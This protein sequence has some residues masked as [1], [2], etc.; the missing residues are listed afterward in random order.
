MG[1]VTLYRPRGKK[2]WYAKWLMPDGRYKKRSLKIEDRKLAEQVK[3]QIEES[4]LKQEFGIKQSESMRYQAA[5]TA[6]EKLLPKIT[7]AQ[8]IQKVVWTRFFEFCGH[9]TIN[10]VIRADATMFMK[11]LVSENYAPA[12]VNLYLLY[13]SRVYKALID[14]E[15]YSGSNPFAGRRVSDT[16]PRK[17][18]VIAWEVIERMM[19]AEAGSPS[20]FI[21][22]L[23]GMLDRKSTRLNSSHT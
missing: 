15:L 8:A 2:I 13:C 17:M 19:D 18:R 14:E 3:R 10:K 11:R 23:G 21:A 1:T 6:Y 22:A 9:A 4:M 12:T 20:Y 5:W 7:P 16:G